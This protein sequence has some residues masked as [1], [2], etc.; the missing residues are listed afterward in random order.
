MK[1]IAWVI[2]VLGMGFTVGCASTD[3]EDS[4]SEPSLGAQAQDAPDDGA[5]TSAI[6]TAFAQDELLNTADIDVTAEQGMVTLSGN[7]ASPQ[8]FNRAISLARRVPGVRPP[9]IVSNLVYPR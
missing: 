2:F 5:I 6:K 4:S 9:V 7:V 3:T 1:T 8:A